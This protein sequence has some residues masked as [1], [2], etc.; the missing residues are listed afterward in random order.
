MTSSN[1][2]S[3]DDLLAEYLPRM[4]QLLPLARRAFGSRSV[5]S[6][7]HDASR[8][9]TRLLVEFYE[10]GGSLVTLSR[11]L[12]VTYAGVRRR[13]VSV[14]LPPMP[15]RARS[16]MTLEETEAAVDRIRAAKSLGSLEYHEQL[17]SEYESGVSMA[18]V[19]AGLGLSSAQPLYFGVQRATLR[20]SALS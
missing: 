19:A 7:N 4:R 2:L 5:D 11:D 12:G 9:Y 10:R 13:V 8:E 16:S 17:R 6:P 20:A 3:S 14:Q 15:T 18:K 1:N